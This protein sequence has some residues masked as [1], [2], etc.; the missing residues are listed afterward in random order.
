MTPEVELLDML[1]MRDFTG[2]T[3]GHLKFAHYL[4]HTAAS[5]IVCPVLYQTP[6]SRTVPDNPFNDHEGAT[7]D[8]LRPFPSYFVAGLDWFRLD[9]AGIAP[10]EAPVVNLIQDFR[11]AD[12]RDPA[13]SC[14]ARPAMRICVSSALA[15]A[16]RGHAN[17]E[18]HA[19]PNCIEI[20]PV[21][22]GR[23]LDASPRVFIAG[24]KQPGLARD[25]AAK[26]VEAVG[27]R[28]IS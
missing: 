26:L 24:L 8:A 25:L 13:F 1:F 15:D 9:E 5:G 17:G 6:R 10:G 3:G 14:L 11:F 28:S 4:R 20:D 7:T 21:L 16:I 22:T 18:V 27:S 23:P 2:F 19:I 12:P